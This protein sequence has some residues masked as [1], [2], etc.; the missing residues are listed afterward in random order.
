MNDL[1]TLTASSEECKLLKSSLSHF[2]DLQIITEVFT[3]EQGTLLIALNSVNLGCDSDKS[4]TG[5]KQ[6]SALGE[7]AQ[8]SLCNG[9]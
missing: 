4:T 3:S 5:A 8:R 7:S 6:L 2:S 9:S 1:I